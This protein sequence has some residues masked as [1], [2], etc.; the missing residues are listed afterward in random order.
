MRPGYF[1]VLRSVAT[2]EAIIALHT[3]A[4]R[5]GWIAVFLRACMVSAAR[6]ALRR[7]GG[8]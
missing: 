2:H 6:F 4:D 3:R 7:V 1:G 5:G 8:L